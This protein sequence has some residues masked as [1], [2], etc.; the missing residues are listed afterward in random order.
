MGP[1]S[2]GSLSGS[3][4]LGG[5]TDFSVVPEDYIVD[6][7]DGEWGFHRQ[8]VV[9]GIRVRIRAEND[10][11][12]GPWSAPVTAYPTLDQVGPLTVSR[13]A[14]RLTVSW[15]E[16]I[17]GHRLQGGVEVG[18]PS[19]R[20]TLCDCAYQA[21]CDYG[22]TAGTEYTVRVTA[23]VNGL[24][25]LPSELV[26]GTPRRATVTSVGHRHSS[27]PTPQPPTTPPDDAYH[28]V[29]TVTPRDPR[30]RAR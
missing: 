21:A 1:G 12:E 13:G 7:A 16:V 24:E 29:T 30:D 6:G 22:L 11:G 5:D 9:G 27:T 17:G 28:P 10:A 8:D 23:T 20:G 25:G 2:G 4:P 26:M 3:D 18:W 14:G 19:V 15:P